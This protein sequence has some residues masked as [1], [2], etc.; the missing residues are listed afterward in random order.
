MTK[1]MILE[2]SKDSLLALTAMVEKISKEIVVVPVESL[3]KA[4][5][6][7][8]DDVNFFQAFLLDINLN[9]EKQEDTSGIS[10]AR[11]IRNYRK[12]AFTPIVMITSIA[13][14]E[15]QAYR[16]LHCYQY[17]I[18][19]YEEEE[20]TRLIGKVLFQA[21]ETNEPFVLVKKEGIN[22]KIL[23]KDIV[24]V[25]AIPRG[26]CLVLRKEEMKVPYVSIKQL[27]EKL[28][29]EQFVQCHRMYVVNRDYIDYVDVVNGIIR[30]KE[31]C[32]VEIGVTYKNVIRRL[33]HA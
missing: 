9:E 25:R 1:I 11:E 14:L 5:T 12:Y 13:N 18:K 27:M 24:Y 30:L 4:R 31:A 7:L 2:D 19:P 8:Q 28:P 16:E 17:I 29:G 10:F 32:Q 26:I 21:G 22:Y 3:E 20:I 33:L 6:A 23:C 15:L